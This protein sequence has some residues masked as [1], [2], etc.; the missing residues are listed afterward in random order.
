MKHA[1]P[2]RIQF[3]VLIC[4]VLLATL[5][6]FAQATTGSFAGT[7]R[8]FRRIGRGRARDRHKPGERDR[9]SRRYRRGRPVQILSVP[10]GTY[11][12]DVTKQGFEQATTKDLV[13]LIDQK[14][15]QNFA[16]TIGAVSAVATVTADAPLLQTQSIETGEVIESHQILDLPLLGRNFLDLARLTSGVTS[17]S[18]GDNTLNLSVSGVREFGN[19]ILIDG[20]E[21]SGNRNNDTNLKPSVDA[22]E[23]FKVATSDYSAQFGH[24]AGGVNTIQTKG[25]TNEIHGSTFEFYRPNATAA[26]NYSFSGPGSRQTSTRTISAA[27]SAA[28]SRRTRAFSSA[29][30][31]RNGSATQLP[32]W[33]PYR[34]RI[35]SPTTRMEAWTFRS[36]SIRATDCRLR[37]TTRP[38]TRRFLSQQ[39]PGN[40]IPACPANFAPD[41]SCVSPAGLA[42]L[43]N[44]FPMPTLPGT[45]YGYYNNFLVNAPYQFNS[46]VFSGRFDQVFSAANFSPLF[47]TMRTS[48]R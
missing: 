11:T 35:R 7:Q 47:T 30:T 23:E 38:S 19:S 12:L 37:S 26:D 6:S 10:P 41:G 1:M 45:D 13:L 16:L 48:I 25:G 36:C 21:A 40:V 33:T 17:G 14:I 20:V 5:S 22:V 18:G 27:P 8:R 42:V 28:R 32:I 29:P 15:S 43:K 3:L 39:F 9:V 24:A 44:F 34:R 31:S 4:A 2:S 46:R